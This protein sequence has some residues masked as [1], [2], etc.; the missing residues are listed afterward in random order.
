MIST[1]TGKTSVW[2]VMVELWAALPTEEL[3][4]QYRVVTKS[5]DWRQDLRGTTKSG[6]SAKI[7]ICE[8]SKPK[9]GLGGLKSRYQCVSIVQA[10]S[11]CQ[12]GLTQDKC[13]DKRC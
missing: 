7:E 6:T 11:N 3:E 12:G 10:I 5:D 9:G 13:S 8:S 4:H 1:E 2:F